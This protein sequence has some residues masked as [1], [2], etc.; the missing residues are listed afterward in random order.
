MLYETKFQWVEKGSLENEQFI[1]ASNS[2]FAVSTPERWV[3]HP[4]PQGVVIVCFAP[5][6]HKLK[7]E[8]SS[9]RDPSRTFQFN[10]FRSTKHCKEGSKGVSLSG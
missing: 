8:Y 10:V 7:I 4:L 3:R 9:S 6:D 2:T 5:Q 1:S